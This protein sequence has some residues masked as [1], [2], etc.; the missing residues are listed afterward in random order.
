MNQMLHKLLLSVGM[1]YSLSAFAIP[2]QLTLD[3]GLKVIVE[4]DTRAPLVVQQIWYKVGSVSE[5]D[6]I[7]GISHVL[8]HMMFKGTPSHPKGEFSEI[9][10]QNGGQENAFTSKDYTGYYQKIAADRLELVMQ[11]EADR[12]Q[13]LQLHEQAFKHEVQVVKEERRSRVDDKPRSLLYEQF[14]ATAFIV[15]PD[16]LPVIGWTRDLDEL[17]L[18]ELQ[19]WYERWYSPNNAILVVVGDVNPEEVFRLARKYYGPLKMQKT[20]PT[21]SRAEVPQHGVRR[22]TLEVPAKLPFLLIAFKAPTLAGLPDPADAYALEVL[23]GILDGGE[24]ARFTNHLIRG[25]KLAAS[26][27][28]GYDMYKPRES[29]FLLESTPLATTSL[30]AMENALLGEIELVKKEGVSDQ[31]LKRVKAQ[32]I[33]NDIFSKD[34][35]FARAMSVGRMEILGLGYS[36]L[37]SYVDGIKAVTAEQVQMVAKKYLTKDRMTIGILKPGLSDNEV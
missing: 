16:R 18:S 8:E 14:L 26:T 30:Q 24:S 11:L 13:N 6:G 9:I 22:V 2:Q 12:M 29:L 34:S 3:N 33:A 32:V 4:V 28:V 15:S 36:V 35:T 23:A 17:T 31:E 7:T 10:A 27:G 5:H 19:R 25:R 20:E 21:K 1:I 37:D